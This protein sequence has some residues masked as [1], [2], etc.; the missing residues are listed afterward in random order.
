MLVEAPDSSVR[1]FK[2]VGRYLD[3][4][5]G[6]AV[7]RRATWYYPE[8]RPGNEQLRDRVALHP[9][10]MGSCEI[11]GESVSSQEVGFYGGWITSRMGR[12]VQGGTRDP[13]LVIEATPYGGWV[14]DDLHFQFAGLRARFGRDPQ[15]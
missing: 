7:A 5:V 11:D 6:H 14:S 3:L 2:G 9:G 4:R 12:P 8:P 1:E 10:A 13:G 15:L